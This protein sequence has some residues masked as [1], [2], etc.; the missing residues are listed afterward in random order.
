MEGRDVA[1][2]ARPPVWLPRLQPTSWGILPRGPFVHRWST[3]VQ[4]GPTRGGGVRFRVLV[5]STRPVRGWTT[6]IAADHNGEWVAYE[7]ELSTAKRRRIGNS[8]YGVGL[9]RAFGVLT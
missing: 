9:A 7:H 4:V 1:F 2:G 5:S 8:L 6:H 3:Y